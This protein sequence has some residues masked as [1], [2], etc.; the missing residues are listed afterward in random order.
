MQSIY[1]WMQNQWQ[2]LLS[3]YSAGRLPHALLLSGPEGIGKYDF[4]KQL[5]DTLLCDKNSRVVK[6]QSEITHACGQCNG[7]QLIAA[8]TH[9]DSYLVQPEAEGKQIPIAAIREINQFLS[10]K[11]QFAALQVVTIAPAEA[12]NRNAANALLKTLEE[13]QP[14]KLIILVSSQPGR[15]LPTIRSRCQQI[16]FAL[17][18]PEQALKWLAEKGVE[19]VDQAALKRLLVLSGG[20]PLLARQYA[21]QGKLELYGELLQSFEN[22]SKK[23]ADPVKEARRWETA[24][25]AHSV[26][27]LYL[28]VSS[29]IHLKSV[30]GTVDTNTVGEAPL[31]RE[32][33]LDFLITSTSHSSLYGFLDRLIETSRVINTSVNVQLTLESLLIDWCDQQK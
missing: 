25:L 10:F 13:P 32:P 3:Q 23:Q 26:K 27:W 33:S 5:T 20:A 4:V 31:W 15:L 1:P 28:W 22:L 19:T 30:G 11:S 14:D 9:P 12:M 21:E 7:C 6:E 29:L 17:P 24:G 8:G 16:S 2:H 18:E